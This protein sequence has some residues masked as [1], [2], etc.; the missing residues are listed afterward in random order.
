MYWNDDEQRERENETIKTTVGRLA[1]D[2]KSD[3][4]QNR[5]SVELNSTDWFQFDFTSFLRQIYLSA[6]VV[7]SDQDLVTVSEVEFLFNVSKLLSNSDSRIVQNYFVWRFMMNLAMNMPRAVRQTREQ[8]DRVFKGI[9]SSPSRST[10]CSNYVNDNMGFAVSR[11][12]L[13]YYF[14]ESARTQVSCFD[15]ESRLNFLIALKSREII[16]NVRAA[17]M[18]MLN[19]ADWMDQ[20]SKVKA[21]EKV[22]SFDDS[23]CQNLCLECSRLKLYSRILDIQISLS[24]PIR[25]NWMKCTRMSGETELLFEW[26]TLNDPPDLLLVLFRSVTIHWQRFSFT[27]S[28]SPIG[29]R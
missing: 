4:R 5:F 6:G 7:L 28:Q 10:M 27:S 2:L 1:E 18:D 20:D 16:G 17:F 12:Y 25:L 15:K 13:K 11:L 14:D 23:S 19:A 22:R 21:I 8:F 3:V 29:S 9:S 24:T 26:T